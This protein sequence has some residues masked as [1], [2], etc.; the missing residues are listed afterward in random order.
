MTEETNAS[1]ARDQYIPLFI[2]TENLYYSFGNIADAAKNGIFQSSMICRQAESIQGF[3]CFTNNCSGFECSTFFELEYITPRSEFGDT[4][5]AVPAKTVYNHIFSDETFLA[6]EPFDILVA[7][8]LNI[9]QI[10]AEIPFVNSRF[11][12]ASLKSFLYKNIRQKPDWR[13]FSMKIFTSY[14]SF[15]AQCSQFQNISVQYKKILRSTS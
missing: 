14:L 3:R 8:P 7:R 11:L 13:S 15:Y 10:I 1:Y 4:Q 5:S 12:H 6:N 2:T 9:V